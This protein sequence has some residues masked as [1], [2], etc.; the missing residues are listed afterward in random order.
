MHPDFKD[1]HNDD[2][3]LVRVAGN[4]EFNKFVQPIALPEDD[5]EDFSV[6]AK[7]AGWGKT[8]VCQ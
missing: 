8:E 6:P 4:I 7:F 2:I 3:A 5:I 1:W